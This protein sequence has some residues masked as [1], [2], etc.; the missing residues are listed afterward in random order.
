MCLIFYTYLE[1]KAYAMKIVLLNMKRS[2][3]NEKEESKIHLTLLHAN[4]VRCYKSFS[5]LLNL[6]MV[7]ELCRNRVSLK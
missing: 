4:V 1:N 7:L 2:Q 3:P 5:D 6:Y